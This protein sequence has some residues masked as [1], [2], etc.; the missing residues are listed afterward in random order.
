M[1]EI[2]C[3]G[4]VDIVAMLDIHIPAH[5]AHLKAENSRIFTVIG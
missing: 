3:V 1:G 4:K 5:E 2:V